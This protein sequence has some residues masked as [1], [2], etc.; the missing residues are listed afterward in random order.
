MNPAWKRD[1]LWNAASEARGCVYMCV[2]VCV[3]AAA[4]C[5]VTFF[6]SVS[7]VVTEHADGLCHKLTTVCPTVK[8]QTQGL[9]K[10]AWEI[11]RDSLRLELKLGQGCFGEVWMGKNQTHV[12]KVII[13]H[14]R[15]LLLFTGIKMMGGGDT[16]SD[17]V[18]MN[19]T[20]IYTLYLSCLF[21]SKLENRPLPAAASSVY[22]QPSSQLQPHVSVPRWTASSQG[23]FFLRDVRTWQHTSVQLPELIDDIVSLPD[24]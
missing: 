19:Q 20:N 10:D 1:R 4:G 14:H 24:H 2:Y 17:T 12:H 6:I 7:H 13:Q 9:A 3:C 22:L 21:R 15:I 11:P 18:C 8:P 23:C 5:N 16:E